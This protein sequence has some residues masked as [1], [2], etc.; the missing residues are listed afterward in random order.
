MRHRGKTM[1][2]VGM[3]VAGL[4]LVVLVTTAAAQDPTLVPAETPTLT[5]TQMPQPT[6]LPPVLTLATE[7]SN[8]APQPTN[9]PVSVTPLTAV[10]SEIF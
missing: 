1:K 4:L 9:A 7:T 10:P 3:L 8:P 6:T 2:R 5:L